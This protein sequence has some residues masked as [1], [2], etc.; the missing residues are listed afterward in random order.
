MIKAIFLS[1]IEY[2]SIPVFILEGDW[3]VMADDNSFRYYKSIIQ[4]SDWLIF[5]DGEILDDNDR[6]KLIK[7]W[8][9]GN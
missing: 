9:D 1:D 3:F 5:E 7:K 8:F 2:S 6:Q 4:D